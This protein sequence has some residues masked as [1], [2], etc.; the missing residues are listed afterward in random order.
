MDA[1][2]QL[3]KRDSLTKRIKD[4]D[5]E[6]E[7]TD[8][9][10]L[11]DR[12][13]SDYDKYDSELNDYKNQVGSFEDL[14]SNDPHAAQFVTDLSAGRDPWVALIE[15]IGA[16]GI[17]DMLN[18]PEK[19]EA[20]AAANK[21]YLKR[22]ATEKEINEK[23]KENLKASR[24]LVDSIIAEGISEEDM[25]NALDY[26][27]EVANELLDG[28]YSEKAIRMALKA[29]GYDRDIAEADQAGEVRGRNAKVEMSMRR[30]RQGDGVPSLNGANNAP[31]GLAPRNIFD[32][33]RNA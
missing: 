27:T 6:F 8:D 16:D 2:T 11:F 33:A 29:L 32:Q 15:R 13:G 22:V 14:L 12:I 20:Y 25:D 26:L 9:E 31:E 18:D 1:S 4:R 30:P 3:S 28:T 17:T 19:L 23:R 21:E 24:E 5:P 7:Y 10:A